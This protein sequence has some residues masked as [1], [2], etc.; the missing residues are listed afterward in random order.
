V[1]LDHPEDCAKRLRKQAPTALDNQR[2]Q[3]HRD[4]RR[5][6]RQAAIAA[7]GWDADMEDEDLL[8]APWR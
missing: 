4:A 2:P 1:V 5:R 3:S 6:L 8:A 7:Y